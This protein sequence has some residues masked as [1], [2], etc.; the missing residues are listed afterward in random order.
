VNKATP[1][2]SKV[3]VEQGH[4]IKVKKGSVKQMGSKNHLKKPHIRSIGATLQQVVANLRCQF[5]NNPCNSDVVG[6]S[7]FLLQHK[8]S[9]NKE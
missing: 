1:S 8:R 4:Y 3:P 5:K 7:F 9:S 6:S 2:K